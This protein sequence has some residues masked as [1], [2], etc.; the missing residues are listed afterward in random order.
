MRIFLLK[1]KIHRA[2]VTHADLYYEG[3]ITIDQDLIDAAEM[4]PNEKVQVVNNS[5]GARFETYIIA[6]E[7]GSGVV[8]LNGACARLAAV[9]DEVIIMTYADMEPKEAREYKPVVVLVD[10]N[11]RVLHRYRIGETAAEPSYDIA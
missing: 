1:S 10:K 3:S 6:G 2:S 9:G 11:N 4:I 7:R 8:Q 5:N